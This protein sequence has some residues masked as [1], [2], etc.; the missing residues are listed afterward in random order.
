MA[1]HRYSS[2]T[3]VMLAV[4]T[5]AV[6][7]AMA[8]C[9]D[10]P[11]AARA[12]RVPPD[13]SELAA[14][15]MLEGVLFSFRFNTGFKERERLVIRNADQWAQAWARITQNVQPARPVPAVDFAR[16]M[17]V[18]V[19]IGQR[20]TGGYVITIDGVSEADG[21]LYAEVRERSPGRGCNTSEGLTQPIDVV[22]VPRREGT[23]F[24]VERVETF[25]CR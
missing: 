23:V 19:A 10:S 21:R 25:E 1:R 9:S 24:F 5:L 11:T 22:R 7:V 18:L 6:A 2:V 8:G 16:E 14:A 4:V 20:P 17:I 12:P 13:A 15:R 3:V